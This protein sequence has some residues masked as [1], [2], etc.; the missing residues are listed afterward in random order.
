MVDGGDCGRLR[1]SLNE[2]LNYLLLF[3]TKRSI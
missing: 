2:L 3:A 1:N